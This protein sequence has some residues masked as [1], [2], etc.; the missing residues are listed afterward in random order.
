MAYCKVLYHW[1]TLATS[2]AS[3]GGAK[4]YASDAGLRALQSAM[5][6]RGIEAEV[7]S[8]GPNGIYCVHYAIKNNDL[9]SVIIPTKDGYDNIER[10]VSSIIKKTD[11]PNFEIIIADNGSTNSHMW[12]LY[13]RFENSWE[14]ASVLKRLIFHSISLE[15]II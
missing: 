9:V 8:A 12:D 3:S 1:R 6:R 13:A 11:Y 2:T 5:K 14:I 10:C 4:S 7:T 15:S